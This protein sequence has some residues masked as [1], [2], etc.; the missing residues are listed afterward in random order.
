MRYDCFQLIHLHFLAQS[1]PSSQS[2]LNELQYQNFR[3]TVQP[4]AIVANMAE[5]AGD[6]NDPGVG[7]A[8]E[9]KC[10]VCNK[11]YPKR[12][13]LEE[14]LRTHTG[15]KPFSCPDCDK[16]FTRK[17]DMVAHRRTHNKQR[18]KPYSCPECKNT[19]DTPGKL[20]DHRRTHTGEKPFKCPICD[21]PFAKK[22][23]MERHRLTHNSQREKPTH[24]SQRKKPTH[25][26][27]SVKPFSCP[28]CQL[29]FYNQVDLKTHQA[30]VHWAEMPIPDPEEGIPQ[31]RR[32]KRSSS[33]T[34]APA[35]KRLRIPARDTNNHLDAAPKWQD[36]GLPPLDPTS[37]DNSNIKRLYD[38]VERGLTVKGEGEDAR[39]TPV[40]NSLQHV[41]TLPPHDSANREYRLD[42]DGVRL[43]DHQSSDGQVYRAWRLRARNLSQPNEPEVDIFTIHDTIPH[44]SDKMH[45][46]MELMMDGKLK[47][48]QILDR[49]EAE[50]GVQDISPLVLKNCCDEL[51]HLLDMVKLKSGQGINLIDDTICGEDDRHLVLE[52]GRIAVDIMN[53]APFALDVHKWARQWS[54]FPLQKRSLKQRRDLFIRVSRSRTFIIVASLLEWKQK[55]HHSFDMDSVHGGLSPHAFELSTRS[56]VVLTRESQLRHE[57]PAGIWLL[58]SGQ[59]DIENKTRLPVYLSLEDLDKDKVDARALDDGYGFQPWSFEESKDTKAQIGLKVMR[60]AFTELAGMVGSPSGVLQAFSA[61]TKS[62]STR[63]SRSIKTSPVSTYVK[64]D[65]RYN[66]GTLWAAPAYYPSGG[67]EYPRLSLTKKAMKGLDLS[68]LVGPDGTFYDSNLRSFVIPSTD[69]ATLAYVYQQSLDALAALSS[70]NMLAVMVPALQCLDDISLGRIDRP[71]VVANYCSCPNLKKQRTTEHYC[72]KCLRVD[73]CVDLTWK[74][75]EDGNEL[76]CRLCY[77]DPIQT[78]RAAYDA[79]L[80]KLRKA[81]EGAYRS[82]SRAH[83]P[84]EV[85][86]VMNE[87]EQYLIENFMIEEDGQLKWKDGYTGKLV[88]PNDTKFK[89]VDAFLK[90]NARRIGHPRAFSIEKVAQRCLTDSDNLALHYPSNTILTEWALN[91]FKGVSAVS[92]LPKGKQCIQLRREVQD[93]PPC[94]GYHDAVAERREVLDRAL[95]NQAM[96]DAYVPAFSRSRLDASIEYSDLNTEMEDGASGVWSLRLL[97]SN[98]RSLFATRGQIETSVARKEDGTPKFTMDDEN[99][100]WQV[101]VNCVDQIEGNTDPENGFNKHNMELPRL[102]PHEIPWP[103]REDTCPEDVD[104]E[105]IF[106][107]FRARLKTWDEQCDSHHITHESPATLFIEY[108]V[109]WFETGGK[110]HWLGCIMTPYCGHPSNFSFGRGLMQKVRDGP[111]VPI[112]AGDEMKTG[113]KV[114]LPYNMFTDYDITRRTSIAETWKANRTRFHHI[115]EKE[116]PLMTTLDQAVLD[117]QDTCEHYGPLKATLDGYT[118]VPLPRSYKDRIAWLNEVRA[119]CGKPTEDAETSPEASAPQADEVFDEELAFYEHGDLELDEGIAGQFSE[120]EEDEEDEQEDEEEARQEGDSDAEVEDDEEDEDDE[121]EEDDD[122]EEDEG[123]I[124]RGTLAPSAGTTFGRPPV[125]GPS[126]GNRLSTGHARNQNT[127]S[128]ICRQCGQPGRGSNI[129]MCT[130]PGHEDR[131]MHFH[132]AGFSAMP[133]I[134]DYLGSCSEC[135]NSPLSTHGVPANVPNLRNLGASCYMSSSAMLLYFLDPIRELIMK[136]DGLLARPDRQSGRTARHWLPSSCKVNKTTSDEE[137]DRMSAGHMNNIKYLFAAFG[138]LFQLMREGKGRISGPDSRKFLVSPHWSYDHATILTVSSSDCKTSTRKNSAFSTRT[139]LLSFSPTSWMHSYSLPITRPPGHNRSLP[140]S[141]RP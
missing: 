15:E 141:I 77:D 3:W 25:N 53:R 24:D 120:D 99:W 37:S 49:L 115:D 92:M 93:L 110:C 91:N 128:L 33:P 59:P 112:E 80:G 126:T 18:E 36:L 84:G 10:S 86:F 34:K 4:R 23:T 94:R 13:K 87:L 64:R 72:M 127:G 102:G 122:E 55:H 5:D 7:Q 45:L 119:L 73:K 47:E 134:D 11:T 90:A 82:D 123:S 96:I 97:P 43:Y 114:L 98:L 88:D 61:I 131:H 108:I 69:R 30:I 32:R 17:A 79:V 50:K 133:E 20:E 51:R 60:I 76:L 138:D 125:L 136:K 89:T 22:G 48:K 100:D 42:E 95:D 75:C 117:L 71:H 46:A 26:S 58:D 137:I 101:I 19:F 2:F 35:R 44:P 6:E 38:L 68:S 116:A 16:P 81:V 52:L 63:H 135:R 12:S 111:D 65:G 83:A 8:R 9:H 28:D 39:Y 105:F 140:R 54:Q 62:F 113:C 27:Q 107:E 132:C 118:N 74:E 66:G 1:K 29:G 14:H 85:P 78:G 139:I 40:D 121:E 104:E 129:I 103:F 56:P 41:R 67:E 106:N 109:Q 57:V 130:T 21:K 124:E 70:K 31:G